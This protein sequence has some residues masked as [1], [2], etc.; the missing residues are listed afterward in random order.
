M[1]LV[2]PYAAGG[3]L[4]GKLNPRKMLLPLLTG[5][6][7]SGTGMFAAAA[8]ACPIFFTVLLAL[9]GF[10]MGAICS[11]AL[12]LLMECADITER[13][14]TISTLYLAGYLGTSIPSFLLGYFVP[15][16]GLGTIGLAFS[17]GLPWFGSALSPLGV[18]PLSLTAAAR[19]SS[20]NRPLRWN[21]IQASR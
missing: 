8:Y 19:L 11:L 3:I 15:N 7:V 18:S 5:Y 17:V 12:K 21:D 14:Q 1:L 2:A 4:C 20:R 10:I 6:L 9:C 16:A 13:A